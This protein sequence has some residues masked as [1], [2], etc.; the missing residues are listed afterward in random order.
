MGGRQLRTECCGK[1][2]KFKKIDDSIHRPMYD[3]MHK[4]LTE[5]KGYYRKLIKGR[6]DTVEPVLGT[7]INH[8]ICVVYILV[9]WQ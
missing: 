3:K 1:V 5:N 8:H 2:T 6:S 7:L 4:K 9:A